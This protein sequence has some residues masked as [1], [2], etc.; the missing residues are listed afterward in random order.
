MR[1]QYVILTI[2]HSSG[3]LKLPLIFY[4]S[5]QH[6]ALFSLIQPAATAIRHKDLNMK[7]EASYIT[8]SAV[9]YLLQ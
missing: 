4:S 1:L 3:K 5:S 6:L 7:P 2:H 8:Q 9:L